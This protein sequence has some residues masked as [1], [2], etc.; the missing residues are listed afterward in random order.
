VLERLR[1]RAQ[2]TR[3]DSARFVESAGAVEEERTVEANEPAVD[4]QLL[5]VERTYRPQ[6]RRG[7][8]LRI[9][10]KIDD[11]VG[12]LTVSVPW[13]SM[14]QLRAQLTRWGRETGDDDILGFIIVPWALDRVATA[15]DALPSGETL[16]LEFENGPR[17]VA[18]TDLLGR[19]GF[20]PSEPQRPIE[21]D[22]PWV[23]E[24]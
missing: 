1:K 5:E 9:V 21:G 2:P 13:E 11:Q 10:Y 17:P 23:W 4:V 16:T 18:V 6:E 12:V 15:R 3:D 20:Q 24:G 22:R 14:A 19:Y 7:D 8:Y